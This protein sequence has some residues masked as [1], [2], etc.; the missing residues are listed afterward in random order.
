M[1]SKMALLLLGGTPAAGTRILFFQAALLG[2]YVYAHVVTSVRA[3][4]L[5][6]VH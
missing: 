5:M 3:A 4:G 6:A 2:G 1:F